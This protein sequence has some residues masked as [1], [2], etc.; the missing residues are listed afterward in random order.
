MSPTKLLMLVRLRVA[1]LPERAFLHSVRS[2]T[3]GDLTCTSVSEPLHGQHPPE[4]CLKI[5][6]VPPSKQTVNKTSHIKFC[7]AQQLL[8][9]LTTTQNT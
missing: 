6:I 7:Q 2:A 3:Y 1:S 8:Y 4:L 9:I 5:Q